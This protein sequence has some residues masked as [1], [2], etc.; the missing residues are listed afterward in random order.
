MPCSDFGLHLCVPV[1]SSIMSFKHL[2]ASLVCIAAACAAQTA[3]AQSLHNVALMPQFFE[4]NQGQAER[5]VDFLSRGPGYALSLKPNEADLQLISVPRTPGP[6]SHA[7]LRMKLLAAN[8][9]A[10]PSGQNLQ[11]ALSNYLIGNAAASW[12]TGIPHYGR[13][14]YRDVYPGID[15]AY[16]GNQQQLEYD[17]ILRPQADVDR[18]Q[19]EFQGASGLLIDSASGDILLELGSATIRQKAPV[20]YQQT[21]D[22]RR[23]IA[24]KYVKRGRSRVGLQVASYDRTGILVIDPVL[25]FST[26]YGGNGSDGVSGIV[27]D[28]AGNVY[29]CGTTGSVN[30]TGTN[31]G[32]GVTSGYSAAF[33]AKISPAGALLFATFIA[34]LSDTATSA[35]VALDASGNIY[36]VG[37]TTSSS[38][39]TAN[40]IQAAY[41]GGTDAFLLELNSSGNALVFSTYIGGSGY[42]YFDGL[43]I[44][45]NGNIY[46]GGATTSSDFPVQNAAEPTTPA[47][48][49]GSYTAFGL[50]VTGMALAY[51]TYVGA[52]NYTNKI[53]IDAQGDLYVVGDVTSASFP[54]TPHAYQTVYAGST[55]GFVQ[56][57]SPTGAILYSTYIGGSGGDAVRA[58]GVDP[59][60]NLIIGGSTTSTDFPVLNPIQA[61]YGGGAEDG[62]LA[63]LSSDGSTLLFSTYLGG[64]GSDRVSHLT[65]D[66]GGNVYAI[67]RTGSSNFPT[68]QPV[69]GSFGGGTFDAYLTELN[70]SGSAILFSTYLGGSG[71][72]EGNVVA[73]DTQGNVYLGGKTASTDFPLLQPFQTQFGGGTADGFI[74]EMAFCA[75]SLSPSSALLSLSGGTGSFTVTTSPSCGWT[76]ATTNSWITIAPPV[77]GSGSATI[78]YS[79]APN[80]TAQAGNITIG[81]QTFTIVESGT[82]TLASVAPAMGTLGSTIPVTLTGS[83]F[84][85]GAI[86]AVNNPGVMVN[87]VVVVS[88][89]QITATLTISPTAAT[90]AASVTVTTAAGIGGPASFTI[91]QPTINPASLTLSPAA[92]VGGI[93]TTANT[94]TLTGA[95]PAGGAIVTL[96]SNNPAATVP[97]SVTVAAGAT[98]SP[99][100]TISTTAVTAT[101]PAVISATYNG[102]T[103]TATLSVTPP[104]VGGMPVLQLHADAS[105]IAGTQNGAV[106]TP[107][108][109]PSGLTGTVV[110]NGTGSVNFAPAAS[111]NGVYF[112]NCCGN[113]NNAYYKFTGAAVG[114]VFNVNQGEITFFLKS[115]YTFAQ[116]KTS[117]SVQR[118]AFDARDGSG[119]HLFNFMT[120]IS[121]GYLLFTYA[122]GGV[123][124]YYY[125]PPGTE[126][127]LFGNGVLLQVTMAWGG[128]IS[129]LYLNGTLVKSAKFTAP[130]ANWNAAS[131][132][133]LGAFEYLTYGGYDSSD[134]VIDEFTVFP[135][136]LSVSVTA[137]TAAATESGTVAVTANAT[138]IVSLKNVQFQLDGAN[139]GSAVTGAGP[140]YSY[141]WDT[142]TATN[143]PH[144]LSAVATDSAGNSSTSA[145]VSV[146]VNNVTTPPTVSAVTLSPGSVLGGTATTL[147]TITL[148]GPAPNGGAVV[149]LTSNNP[150]A[151]VPASVTVA[152]AA[153]VSPAFAITTTA[154]AANI[155]ATISAT[156]SGSTLTGTLTVLAPS[157]SAVSL[158][159]ASVLGGTSTTL[160]TVTLN[161]PAP[162]GGAVVTLMSNNAAAV[163]PASVTVAAGATVSPAF[164]IAT[165]SVSTAT[166]VTIS[167]TYGATVSATLTVGPLTASVV[168]LTSS[169]VL[170]GV[171]T[172]GTV[173]LNG[174][175][176]AGGVVVAL[177]SSDPSTTVPLSVTVA[178][179][180]TVSPTFPI[181]T[182]AVTSTIPVTI[183]ATYNGPAATAILTVLPPGAS[184]VM[185]SPSSVM[186]GISTTANTVTLNS[187]AAPA[188]AVVTLTSNNA[189]AVVPA[190]VT[191]AGGATISPAFTITTSAV[192]ANMPVTISATYGGVTATA[193]LTVQPPSPSTVSLSLASVQGGTSVTANTVTLNGPAAPAGAV[194]TLTSSSP[195]AVVPASVT[196]A[197]GG[198]VS[199]AFTITTTAVS[200]STPITISATYG[201]ITATAALT[202][203]PPSPS[204]LTISQASVLGGTSVTANTV[205]LSGPAPSGG[206]V[207]TLN[208][209]SPAAAVPASVTVAAGATVTP[210]FTITTTAVSASTP[211]T[212]SATYGGVTATGAL[213]V[214]PPSPSAVNL[215]PASVLG[216]TSTTLNTVTLNGPAPAGGAI[217][218]LASNNPAAVVPASVTVAAGATVSPAFTITT[219]LVSTSTPASISATYNGVTVPATLTVGPLMPTVVTLA[220]TS[221]LGGV[222]TTATVTL[223]GPA[224]A[225][226]AIV[227]L[228]SN[229]AAATVPASVTVAGSA[230]VSPSFT[231]STTAV[232]ATTP[233]TI[234]ATYNGVTVAATLSVTPPPVGGSPVLQLHADASE[235]SGT[236]N[237][238]IVTPSTGPSGL[239]GTVVVN[240]SGSVN[241][242]PAESGNG[243]YFL[244]CC[245]NGNNAYYK[246]TGAALGNVFNVNQGQITF[247]LKS[248]YSF[249][250]RK[251]NASGQRYA[252][253][254]KDGSGNHLFNFMTQVSSGYLLFT[255]AE[256]GASSYYYVPPGTEDALFGN[257]VLLQ[258]TMTWGNGVSSLYL[259]GTLVK[260]AGFSP[261]AV[262]WNAAS[263][264][265]LGAFDYLTYGGYS[266]S[267]DVID[268]FTVLW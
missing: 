133:D 81:N 15:I 80:A 222:S 252:F 178:G 5:G 157:P 166:P 96:A 37:S 209:N 75:Y 6:A 266:S 16:Y 101:T 76:A 224:P 234:S 201:S 42:D 25:T 184:A 12:R 237:G 194:V 195:A 32:A 77:S 228:A 212:I 131:V 257:G 268:E 153:T 91:N 262:N 221:V 144:T 130:T 54:T 159:P 70:N 189:A 145:G 49:S 36:V 139:L 160:N 192:A 165:S 99:S 41:H 116:R 229:N 249:A 265:D 87:N 63:K 10:H 48:G 199:P 148:S 95:A 243:V 22:G 23:L 214:Q 58:V 176:P 47:A 115:R 142:T 185:L 177:A 14:E 167:A 20:V 225:G 93:S 65:V 66:G 261:P 246:F 149:T 198:T 126:D 202:V 31:I 241:F 188:G 175:A 242:A 114:N 219:T 52:Y 238:A 210:S 235:V 9:H 154:V 138:D 59:N 236:Q 71:D 26:Y 122:A 146:T 11:P 170:G 85:T 226:G 105:E 132:F 186:G 217:V 125:V 102:V 150:A 107:S 53:A 113:T 197:G 94:V 211:V 244:N 34:G 72:D 250:Q 164:T 173:S 259:N 89:T 205:T 245:G 218:T 213:T 233:V 124:N 100:F 136:P 263:N 19:L 155:P 27:T 98:V 190:S 118:Y 204:T 112:L 88:D 247:Y 248:R 104:P 253:D 227:T 258:V 168:T 193:T 83:N 169:S 151:V 8:V 206:A 21:P 3:A 64:N 127:A 156:Y 62:W 29:I 267:D 117:A 232:T 39:P 56:K 46:G 137:P 82:V 171:S 163:V 79:A 38:F 187:P 254:V 92:V 18:I 106:L 220:S 28:A 24:A 68:A 61:A 108:T 256:S 161:G 4:P 51:S 180:T 97:A 196:V 7:A 103:V 128:G 239:T 158:S 44:D 45:S 73:V 57:L 35:S 134:D 30:L 215:S 2:A 174:P 141:N 240:G 84:V 55:D 191:V 200:A 40:P 90:G 172:T 78:G 121:S 129:D 216:G 208:S 1:R 207:V 120:Q 74:A 50:K 119:N 181:T 203:Q 260:S 111:G 86:V 33:V 255:Y 135:S 183:S 17:F 251:A 179:G 162:A 60:G 43:A 110:V 143:G 13:V 69:Q 231:I 223:N 182:T 147:N 152:A 140:A 109:G 123:T 67:G 264:F 230:T